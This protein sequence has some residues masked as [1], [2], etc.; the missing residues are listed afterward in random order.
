MSYIRCQ[1]FFII[2]GNKKVRTYFDKVCIART[3]HDLNL[4]SPRFDYSCL[5]LTFPALFTLGFSVLCYCIAKYS[6]HGL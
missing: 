1:A 5:F 3:L 4:I 6:L 2:F